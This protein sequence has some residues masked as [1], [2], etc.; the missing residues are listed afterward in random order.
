MRLSRDNRATA[1]ARR[2][3]GLTMTMKRKTS[4]PRAPKVKPVAHEELADTLRGL[5][6]HMEGLG[7]RDHP[8]LQPAKALVERLNDKRDT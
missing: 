6:T 4:K 2:G 3:K 5:V 8:L 1:A 7:H